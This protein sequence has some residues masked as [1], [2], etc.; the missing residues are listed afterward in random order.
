MGW[1]FAILWATVWGVMAKSDYDILS[2]L[3]NEHM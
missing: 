1:E 3:Q 2:Q